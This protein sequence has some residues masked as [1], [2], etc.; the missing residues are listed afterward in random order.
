MENNNSRVAL[1]TGGGRGIGT[2]ICQRLAA[3]GFAVAVN[4]SRSREEAELVVKKIKE[5]GG[6]AVALQADIA[7]AAEAAE[8]VAQTTRVLG[9]PDVVV[10][11]AGMNKGGS[12]RKL[13][14]EDW[15]RVIGV[16]LS[17][18]FYCTQAALPAM[19]E[20]GWGRIIFTSSP[21]ASRVPMPTES[22]YAAAKA[23]LLA[24]S[25]VLAK[26]VGR[27]GITV[28]TVMPGFVDTEMPRA[29]GEKAIAALEAA[30]PRIPAEAIASSIAYLASDEA[31]YVSGEELGVWG[32]GPVNI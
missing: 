24:M 19:Y 4:Y 7:D 18:A 9:A 11:N 6:R 1:V 23:G 27:H 17:G 31:K 3:D 29:S 30:W 26:E 25:R 20:K 32:G 12:G 14:P 21:V 16:N 28:N 2:A 22:A 8:L 10:N 13:A 5:A 15:D